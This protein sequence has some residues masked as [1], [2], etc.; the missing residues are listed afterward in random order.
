MLPDGVVQLDGDLI[1]IGRGKG[2][3]SEPYIKFS[4]YKSQLTTVIDEVMGVFNSFTTNFAIPV[5]APGTPHPGLTAAIPAVTKAI[6]SLTAL[7]AS[8]DEAKSDRIFGE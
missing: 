2:D 6:S 5:A 8:I 1:Y 7:K 3:A 4:K